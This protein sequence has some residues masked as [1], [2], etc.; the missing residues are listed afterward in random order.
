[1]H[2]N[3]ESLLKHFQLDNFKQLA[4]TFAMDLDGPE[5]T[6]GLRKM[7]EAEDCI[8]RAKREKEAKG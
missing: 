2:P 3:T 7:L 8:L 1:M 5:L 6:A 4:Q